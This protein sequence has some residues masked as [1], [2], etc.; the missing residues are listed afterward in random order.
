MDSYGWLDIVGAQPTEF[1]VPGSGSF[2]VMKNLQNGSFE[3]AFALE[4]PSGTVDI[5]VDDF[6][7]DQ[8]KDFVVVD[9]GSGASGGNVVVVF[10]TA[11]RKRLKKFSAKA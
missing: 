5:A 4:T 9:R 7:N 2:F 3:S 11:A 6:N 10:Q 8:F 1:A